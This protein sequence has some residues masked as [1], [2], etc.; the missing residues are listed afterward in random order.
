MKKLA[1]L[2]A[3]LFMTSTS[4]I[5]CRETER[6]VDEVETEEMEMEDEEVLEEDEEVFENEEF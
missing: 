4:F 1:V 2:F 3:F 6:E 5:S